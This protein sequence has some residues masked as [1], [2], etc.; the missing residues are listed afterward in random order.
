[1]Y[2]HITDVL[3][4]TETSHK[5][6]EFAN[7]RIAPDTKL[8]L[9]PCL[10]DT[11]IS[12]W[13]LQAK[14]T[15][16]S[17]FNQFFKLYKE[18]APDT[19][20]MALSSHLHEINATHFG[21]GNGNNGKA[22][23]PQGMI[24]SFESVSNLF[25]KGLPLSKA[26]D[27][28]LFIRDF[29]EDCLSDMLTNILL[30]H[31]MDFTVEQCQK[32]H[33][34]TQNAPEG[35]FYWDPDLDDWVEYTGQCMMYKGKLLLLVP[36]EIV[37]NRYC[38]TINQFFSRVILSR[39]QDQ[40]AYVDMNGKPQKTSKKVLRKKVLHGEKVTT[41]AQIMASDDPSYL[42]DYHEKLPLFYIDKAFSDEKLDSIV[43]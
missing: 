31:L 7:V 27:L 28:P 11:G 5:N 12:E 15:V 23:T 6:L 19:E 33:Y 29:A 14:R 32:Y 36:K 10:I 25:E 35:L 39:L 38:F 8:F 34:P 17:F 16:E 37:R 9:D 41:V 3:G 26:C 21:Y 43:K 1:M 22:K 13:T 24:Q 2:T 4:I 40:T 20:K 18:N 30:K 42:S